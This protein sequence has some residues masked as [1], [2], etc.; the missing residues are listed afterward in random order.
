M[1]QQ[2]SVT[3]FSDM[4]VSPEM[5]AELMET[6]DLT[7]NDLGNHKT[8]GK[9]KDVFS[10]LGRFDKGSVDLMVKRITAGKPAHEK[11]D[12]LFEYVSLKKGLMEEMSDFNELEERYKEKKKNIDSITQSLKILER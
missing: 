4:G 11:L 2:Q 6:L 10:F 9:L 7:P 3:P 5:G 1:D 8:F 12:F